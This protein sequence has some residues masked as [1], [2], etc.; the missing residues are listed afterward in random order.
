V[1]WAKA[2]DIVVASDRFRPNGN[3]KRGQVAQWLFMLAATPE[4][5]AGGAT[6]P[7][8]TAFDS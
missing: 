8:T 6:L 5:W 7:P 3:A 2:H 1:R 4:A